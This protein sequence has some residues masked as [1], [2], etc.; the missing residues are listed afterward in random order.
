MVDW[1]K[2]N[3]YKIHQ[4]RVHFR[5]VNY[6]FSI[7]CDTKKNRHKML[8]QKS[9][10]QK[11][12]KRGVEINP[13]LYDFDLLFYYLD[14]VS[15]CLSE[16]LNKIAFWEFEIWPNRNIFWNNGFKDERNIKPG[17]QKITLWNNKNLVRKINY[18][19]SKVLVIVKI[20]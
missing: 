18:S 3:S 2:K 1:I 20:H 10:F 16:K 5:I 8:M 6:H 14:K 15:V 17:T 4:Q 9:L 12:G 19:N 13:I 7:T 11:E